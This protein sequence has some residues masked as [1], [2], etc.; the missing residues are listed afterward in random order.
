MDIDLVAQRTFA[1]RGH[2]WEQYAWLRANDPVHWHDEADGPGF[3]AIT[4]YDDIRTVSRQPGTFSSYERGTMLAEPDE[5]NLA[6]GRQMM[7]NMDPPQHDRF[8]LLVSR[9]FTP[10]N[11]QLLAAR[12]AELSTEIIDDVIG[13]G[14][15]DF[16]TDIAG[17]LPSALIAELMGIPRADGE[18]L[19]ELTELMHTTDD[20]VASPEQRGMAVF[21]MLTYAQQVAE[22][23][24]ANPG[25][26]I[27]SALVQA[28][29]DGDRL[30]DGEFQ[31][32]FLLLVNAGGDTTR[33]LLAA[34]LQAL[35][36]HPSERARLAADPVALV[37]TAVEEMLRF[38]TPVVHFRRTVMQPVEMRGTQLSPGDKVMV[39]YGSANRDEDVFTDPDRFDVGRNPNPHMAFGGGGPHLCLGMHVARIELQAML[40]QIVTRL[41]DLEPAGPI[42]PMASN[43]I[44]GIHSMP[45]RF[46]PGR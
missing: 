6:A 29:V 7:L 30:T 37:P 11:S 45:V 10:R 40:H 20:A 22:Q 28:E 19:Y 2:P 21:E 14:E 35:F 34:G 44:A 1:E 3:W 17:R 25:D 24:R 33:N 15:C 46:T 16:V 39:F 23:K 12:I 43:F 41:P 38:T 5:M 42:E 8:K 31:W 4:K 27:A 32:F 9:G 18:R 26:D 13:R 36:D